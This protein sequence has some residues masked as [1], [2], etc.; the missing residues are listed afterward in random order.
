VN[1]VLGKQSLKR[2]SGSLSE[3]RRRQ[4]RETRPLDAP[5]GC[6]AERQVESWHVVLIRVHLGDEQKVVPDSAWLTEFAGDEL[7]EGRDG[8]APVR[9]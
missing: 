4:K 5:F 8:F 3:R 2:V 9:G 6:F 7:A 1:D